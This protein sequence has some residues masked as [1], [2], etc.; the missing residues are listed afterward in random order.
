MRRRHLRDLGS[1]WVRQGTY[2][3]LEVDVGLAAAVYAGDVIAELDLLARG[4]VLDGEEA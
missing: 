4:W 1:D 2:L 3:R